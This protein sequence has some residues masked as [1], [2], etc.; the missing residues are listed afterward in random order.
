MKNEPEDSRMFTKK[1]V[2]I[3]ALLF[4]IYTWALLGLDPEWVLWAGS[5]SL[6]ALSIPDVG[7]PRLFDDPREALQVA[8]V[9]VLLGLFVLLLLMLT[10]GDVRFGWLSWLHGR[11][12]E[13]KSQLEIPGGSPKSP[14]SLRASGMLPPDHVD[15]DR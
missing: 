14:D 5:M 7:P 10:V 12:R 11:L 4:S 6:G 13:W 3:A 9:F 15:L 2:S 1:G 8:S